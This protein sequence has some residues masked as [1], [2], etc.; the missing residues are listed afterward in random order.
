MKNLI[1]TFCLVSGVSVAYA[2][3][4]K[5]T[6]DTQMQGT[7]NDVEITRKIRDRLTSDESLSTSAQ[8]IT[9]VTLGDTVT[10]KGNVEK[11]DEVNKITNAAQEIAAG[12]KIKNQLRVT[13]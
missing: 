7:S 1:L 6:A 13:R 5:K 11:R 10:L 3:A 12:K 4:A 9:I 2:E 8:N